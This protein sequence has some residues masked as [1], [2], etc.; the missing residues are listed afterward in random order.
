[1]ETNPRVVNGQQVSEGDMVLMESQWRAVRERKAAASF[2][3]RWPEQDGVPT[4][5]YYLDTHYGMKKKKKKKVSILK[6]TKTIIDGKH[7]ACC[8]L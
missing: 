8:E 3:L 5:P 4:V 2:A 6:Q 1:M 7:I